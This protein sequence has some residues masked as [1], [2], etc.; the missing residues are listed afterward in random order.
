MLKRL[1][2][3]FS[4]LSYM[5]RLVPFC[6][7]T[8]IINGGTSMPASAFSNCTKLT[9]V[10]IPASVTSIGSSAFSGCTGLTSITIPNSVTS[11]GSG[12]FYG[13]SN[14]TS[15]TFTTTS[16]WYFTSS[17]TATSGTSISV[18]NTATNAKRLTD[19]HPNYY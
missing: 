4:L 6:Q 14:L 8:V 16:G 19:T 2:R 15:V 3:L 10:T 7:T 12:A 13:C 18:T 1:R 5:V 9:S 17:G 11:I